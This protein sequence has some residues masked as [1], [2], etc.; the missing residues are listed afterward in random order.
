MI[1]KK[2]STANVKACDENGIA[3]KALTLKYI[4]SM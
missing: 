3:A 1:L 4:Y 2:K